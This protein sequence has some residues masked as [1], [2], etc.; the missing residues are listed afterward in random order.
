MPKSDAKQELDE[1]SKIREIDKSQEYYLGYPE[2]CG[3]ANIPTNIRAIEKCTN[4]K[5]LLDK[6]D[7]LSLLVM[8]DGGINLQ[9]YANKMENAPA[10]PENISK[11]ERFFIEFHRIICAINMY[12]D[13]GII[14]CDMKPQNIVFS[15]STG[16]L[17]IIDFGLTTT[18]KDILTQSQ[19]STNQLAR[20]HWSYPFEMFFL[21]KNMY[22]GFAKLSK[23]QREQYYESILY[24]IS[25]ARQ[26][27]ATG[28]TSSSNVDKEKTIPPEYVEAIQGFYSYIFD[29]TTDSEE[30]K[31]HMAGFYQTVVIEMTIHKYNAF[32]KKSIQS[33][34]VYGTG[35]TLLYVVKKTKHLLSPKLYDDLYE[36]GYSMVSTQLSERITASELLDRY[37]SILTENDIMKKYAKYFKNHKVANREPIPKYMKTSLNSIHMGDILLNQQDLDKIA[38]SLSL[39]D[40]PKKSPKVGRKRTKKQP[41]QKGGRK[42]P[43]TYK[44]RN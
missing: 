41:I 4:G 34:D 25:G 13:H 26:R 8:N 18:Q 29:H 15:E 3:L 35:I 2:E 7:E 21:N 11:M 19:K 5:E 32:L 33:I 38:V 24:S 9:E 16:S 22:M 17:N 23:Q 14:H 31:Q 12:L 27:A 44:R 36:L 39:D 10:T 30:F 42:N 6:L 28:G 20:Y 43:C 37:E 40:K 1:Y